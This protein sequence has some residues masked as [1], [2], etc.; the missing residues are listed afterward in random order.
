MVNSHAKPG[1]EHGHA[2][3]SNGADAGHPHADVK[4]GNG[5]DDLIGGVATVGVICVA[6]ALVEMSLIPGMIIGVGAMLVPR[7]LPHI[8]NAVEPTFRYTVRGAYKLGQ[9]ARHAF[10]EAEEQ[11]RDIVAEANADSAP[12][13]HQ[14]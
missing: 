7:A 3:D 9:K 1:S 10:A 8:S 4:A 2:G 12:A 13:T 5:S 14:A 11:V 6:A